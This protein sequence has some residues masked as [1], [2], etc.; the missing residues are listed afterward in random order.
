MKKETN[1][2]N[3]ANMLR[4]S[5][6]NELSNTCTRE[7]QSERRILRGMIKRRERGTRIHKSRKM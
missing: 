7:E 5:Q 1:Q 2:N 3:K 4:V 6:V